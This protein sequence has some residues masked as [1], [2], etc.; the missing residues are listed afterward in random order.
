MPSLLKNITNY[1]NNSITYTVL[2]SGNSLS[3]QKHEQVIHKLTRNS[4]TSKVWYLFLL[5][6]KFLVFTYFILLISTPLNNLCSKWYVLLIF[7]HVCSVKI[8][9]KIKYSTQQGTWLIVICPKKKRH[10]SKLSLFFRSKK[11]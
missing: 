8:R 10:S 1:P 9:V 7:T 11:A 4:I 3:Y 2:S 6:Y 5:I